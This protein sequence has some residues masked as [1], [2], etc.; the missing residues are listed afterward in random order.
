MTDLNRRW[1]DERVPLHVESEFYDVDA[2]RAGEDDS[3]RARKPA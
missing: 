1:W 2:F 3:L